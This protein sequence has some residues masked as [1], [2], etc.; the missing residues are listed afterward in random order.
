MSMRPGAVTGPLHELDDPS[1]TDITL[2]GARYWRTGTGSGWSKRAI[3]ARWP[4]LR[5]G[6]VV[7]LLRRRIIRLLES[8]N[9]DL[10][11]AHSPALCGIAALQAA[12]SRHL[13]FVYEVRSFWE[14]ADLNPKRSPLRLLRYHLA[15]NLESFVLRRSDAVVG[16]SRAVLQ[17][18]EARGI[19]PDK[20]HHVPNGVDVARF[21][22]RTRDSVLAEQIGLVDC[23]IFGFIGTL[24]PWE[25]V[26]WLV[27][28]AATLHASGAR[29]KLL[30][31]GDG[32]AG[33]E[34]R[35]LIQQT[36][37]GAYI[38]FL[39]RVPNDSIERYYSLMDFLV[40]PRLNVQI[41]QM[42][43]P[44][45]PLEAMALGKPVLG[46]D[47]GG[48][49]ELVETEKT[50]L[51]FEAENIQDFCRAATRLL[52]EPDLGNTLGT[53][54]KRMTSQERGW[55]VLAKRYEVVYASALKAFGR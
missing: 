47:V 6:S 29:F 51:L 42:V 17:D 52:K 28:A 7:T 32:V 30:I 22:P 44:L 54:A 24:F 31:V 14:D 48:I 9:F 46:S 1:A 23:P 16:I 10:V 37:S 35:R 45:K 41:A 15:R 25:G 53:N 4:V 40:Y 43:T 27:R 38:S 33:P 21:A 20:L 55:A 50:G 12:K 36:A 8:E 5:E 19:P 11:H 3:L 2:D 34:V 18:L 49:R 26:P 13:P 39:G